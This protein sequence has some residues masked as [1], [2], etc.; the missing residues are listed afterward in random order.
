MGR[1]CGTVTYDPFRSIKGKVIIGGDGYCLEDLD[2][3]EKLRTS[4]DVEG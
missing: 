4:V 1:Y 2:E 3:E